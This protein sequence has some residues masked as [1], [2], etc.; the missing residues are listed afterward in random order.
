MSNKDDELIDDDD[1]FVLA[2]DVANML[3]WYAAVR[4]GELTSMTVYTDGTG[5]VHGSGIFNQINLNE[6][7]VAE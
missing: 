1:I 2:P 3:A 5:T 4:A 7:M 6:E